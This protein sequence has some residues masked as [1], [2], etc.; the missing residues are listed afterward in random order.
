MPEEAPVTMARGRA[1]EDMDGNSRKA[2]RGQGVGELAGMAYAPAGILPGR[3]WC[4]EGCRSRNPPSRLPT[5][6]G[7][8][9][10]LTSTC[11]KPE[12]TIACP[13]GCQWYGCLGGQGHDRPS[14]SFRSRRMLVG[15]AFTS[16]GPSRCSGAP[17]LTPR[18]WR[19]LETARTCYSGRRD[20][21]PPSRTKVDTDAAP[22]VYH[23]LHR[24]A[25]RRL[26]RP[27]MSRPT[28]PCLPCWRRTC[29]PRPVPGSR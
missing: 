28:R 4:Q 1:V 5:Q 16:A 23:L 9:R 2:E 29:L 3:G 20:D 6:A 18:C 21:G 15:L 11:W 17:V 25:S 26:R 19:S 10:A 7:V 27:P 22:Q 24:P 13:I 8:A 12:P 14:L